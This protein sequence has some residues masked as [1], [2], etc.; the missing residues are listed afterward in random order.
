MS[1]QYTITKA[2]QTVPA[3]HTF[4][5]PAA[6][7]GSMPEHSFSNT[8]PITSPISSQPFASI[9]NDSTTIPITSQP[10]SSISNKQTFAN[11]KAAICIS[12]QGNAQDQSTKKP[13]SAVNHQFEKKAHHPIVDNTAPQLSVDKSANLVNL[14]LSSN[15]D[16]AGPPSVLQKSTLP[17][18]KIN[19]TVDSHSVS[20]SPPISVNTTI[21]NVFGTPSPIHC[22]PQVIHTPLHTPD[23]FNSAVHTPH[24]TNMTPSSFHKGSTSLP[25][26]ANLKNHKIS[27][28]HNKF[29][30]LS[31][32]LW[33]DDGDGETWISDSYASEI[34]PLDENELHSHHLHV[35]QALNW[36]NMA[37][38]ESFHSWEAM[39]F[40]PLGE[41][42]L[43]TKQPSQS[44]N[45]KTTEGSEYV[46]SPLKTRAQRQ[47]K[48]QPLS[49]TKQLKAKKTVNRELKAYSRRSKSTAQPQT[50]DPDSFQWQLY[51]KDKKMREDET[52]VAKSNGEQHQWKVCVYAKSP[53]VTAGASG[54]ISSPLNAENITIAHEEK[55]K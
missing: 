50:S 28:H 8:L 53:I 33:D 46:P 22:H 18:E 21:N 55:A 44:I 24:L 7:Q 54:I 9:R 4:F 34:D 41:S 31:D 27:K 51:E 38:D 36:G 15:H 5:V 11:F 47:K 23:P 42:S 3:A 35:D 20:I 52:A 12:K 48:G 2:L 1:A 49:L 39:N 19:Y 17:T 32:H 45:N 25:C 13:K 10:S 43:V 14:A 37:E 6:T 29:S 26:T 30:P 40:P 16:C